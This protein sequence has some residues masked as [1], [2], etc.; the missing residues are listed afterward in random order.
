MTHEWFYMDKMPKYIKYNELNDTFSY[1][2]FIE[3]FEL[4]PELFKSTN[5]NYFDRF[6]ISDGFEKTLNAE[7]FK[8]L[9]YEKKIVEFS[10]NK[11]NYSSMIIKKIKKFVLEIFW[12]IISKNRSRTLKFKKVMNY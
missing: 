11:L 9:E 2:N 4:T 10:L 7:D 3:G 6:M 1:I 12:H 5:F 8:E